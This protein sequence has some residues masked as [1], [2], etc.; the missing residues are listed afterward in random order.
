MENSAQ[1]G[2]RNPLWSS[3]Q[4]AFRVSFAL[5]G[6]A[7]SALN[8]GLQQ[9][10]TEKGLRADSCDSNGDHWPLGER[11]G[12]LTVAAWRLSACVCARALVLH[13]VGST[14]WI[15]ESVWQKENCVQ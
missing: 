4:P 6:T 8:L 13:C 3:R 1:V 7:P 12:A 10:C 5:E 11:F 15:K 2:K 14:I 9:H